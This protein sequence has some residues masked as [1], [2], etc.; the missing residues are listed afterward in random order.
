MMN[1]YQSP[2]LDN[3]QENHEDPANA[4]I[5][6]MNSDD[7]P[8]TEH[9]TESKPKRSRPSR[10]K[11][12]KSSNDI[13]PELVL[14]ILNAD[15]TLGQLSNEDTDLLKLLS[16][17]PT[18]VSYHRMIATVVSKEGKAT[19]LKNIESERTILSSLDNPFDAAFK[20][21]GLEREERLEHWLR[22]SAIDI[23]EAKTIAGTD[24]GRWPREWKDAQRESQGLYTLYTHIKDNYLGHLHHIEEVIAE[25]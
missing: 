15:K 10:R 11:S 13:T 9:K 1:D 3:E 2:F 22:A 6:S 12:A 18:S 8:V 25:F 20:L 19:I 17:E 24:N 23:N 21:A 5:V 14:S 7:T 16:G 4:P